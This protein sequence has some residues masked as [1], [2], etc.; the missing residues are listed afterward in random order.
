[1]TEI[2]FN[3]EIYLAYFFNQVKHQFL[4]NRKKFK[5]CFRTTEICVVIITPIFLSLPISQ[6]FPTVVILTT[7]FRIFFVYSHT[8]VSATEVPKF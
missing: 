4:S 5:H 6:L 1:M 8:V 7:N 2:G 3:L